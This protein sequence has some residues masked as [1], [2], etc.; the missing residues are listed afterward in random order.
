MCI[1]IGIN[2]NIQIAIRPVFTARD[3]AKYGGAA[4][5]AWAQIFPVL[6]KCV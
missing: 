2:H 3:G 4:N 5:S 1:R 6:T